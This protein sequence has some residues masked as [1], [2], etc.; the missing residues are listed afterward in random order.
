M[1]TTEE[2]K[3]FSEMWLERELHESELEFI[4]SSESSSAEESFF[5]SVRGTGMTYTFIQLFILHMVV[6]HAIEHNISL[7]ES[8]EQFT[9]ELLL[10]FGY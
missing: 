9:E 1:I 7:K 10:E 2:I 8:M 4:Q 6:S 5:K 3:S